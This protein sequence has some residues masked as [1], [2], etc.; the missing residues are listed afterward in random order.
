MTNGKHQL[1]PLVP[2]WSSKRETRRERN[3]PISWKSCSAIT[4]TDKVLVIK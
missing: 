3:M 4:A 1:Q 2:G